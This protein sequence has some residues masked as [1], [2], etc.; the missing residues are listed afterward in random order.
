[1][2]PCPPIR[3][4]IHA[5]MYTY[6]YRQKDLLGIFLH[7]SNKKMSF[8]V[9][10]KRE[11]HPTGWKKSRLRKKVSLL[12]NELLF[13]F[14]Y[15]NNSFINNEKKKKSLWSIKWIISINSWITIIFGTES[16]I[17]LFIEIIHFIDEKE[18]N[19][20][21]HFGEWNDFI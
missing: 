14:Q 19:I 1:M 4:P 9:S 12:I 18:K 11:S 8:S 13:L 3:S 17:H 10:D 20:C 7:F 16:V 6:I 15:N 21:D 5:R 2:G